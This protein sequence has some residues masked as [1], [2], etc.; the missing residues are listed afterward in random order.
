M[1]SVLTAY[2]NKMA[3]PFDDIWSCNI[4]CKMFSEPTLT[5]A[6]GQQV[7]I[8]SK[9]TF[10][11]NQKTSF[12]SNPGLLNDWHEPYLCATS[13]PQPPMNQEKLF[14]SE[15]SSDFSRELNPRPEFYLNVCFLIINSR[16][17]KCYLGQ[18]HRD[19]VH[20]INKQLLISFADVL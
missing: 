10:V 15:K 3:F 16:L 20:R 9:M 7:Q 13:P 6:L 17:L 12:D 8:S 5:Q 14:V 2:T 1:H 18:S 4:A 11:D 19:C